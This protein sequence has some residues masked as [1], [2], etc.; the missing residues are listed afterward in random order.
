[1]L[2]LS[3]FPCRTTVLFAL[4]GVLCSGTR[5]DTGVAPL[6]YG[7]TVA[8]EM[9]YQDALRERNRRLGIQISVSETLQSDG[10]AYQAGK[11]RGRALFDRPA[12]I[13]ERQENNLLYLTLAPDFGGSC[14]GQDKQP[15]RRS[16]L[17]TPFWP[18]APD[19]GGNELAS[20]L[21]H[22]PT[23]FGHQ[24]ASTGW[25]RTVG[26]AQ[27]SPLNDAHS[28]P[29]S[30]NAQARQLATQH[31]A[32]FIVAGRILDASVSG[33]GWRIGPWLLGED[34]APQQERDWAAPVLMQKPTA[35]RWQWEMWVH[36][37]LTGN[38]LWRQLFTHDMAE[39]KPAQIQ[40]WL[41]EMAAHMTE[42]LSCLPF[43]ARILR[44]EKGQFYLSAGGESSLA[45]GDTLLVYRQA[46]TFPLAATTT[47]DPLGL[48]EQIVGSVTVTQVQPLL[49]VAT[50][51]DGNLRSVQAGDWVRIPL[52]PRPQ[53]D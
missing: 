40:D 46:R 9:A 47:A 50:A 43:T 37:G 7:L 17:I 41:G 30:G 2:T 5:A 51:A 24:L 29:S 44:I 6:Q 8:R 19:R 35:R 52:A 25:F 3:R 12:I 31:H 32:Q 27:W 48:A 34:A 36:D 26:V 20:D 28:Q 1:M 21:P 18:P 13:A 49:A 10:T 16:V 39:A 15:L 22:W 11:L 33:R 4:L 14:V 42:A 23:W 53:T 45:V 38:V